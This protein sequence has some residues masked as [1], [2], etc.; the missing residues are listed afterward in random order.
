MTAGVPAPGRGSYDTLI[1]GAGMSGLAAGIRLA[2]FGRRV[3]VLERHTTI[4]GLNSVYRLRGRNF[5]SGLHA[6]TNFACCGDKRGPL[7]K[8]LRQLRLSW[9]DFALAPQRGSSI[10]FPNVR[11]EFNNDLDLL[12]AE[13]A[14]AFPD[15]VDRFEQLLGRLADYEHLGQPEMQVASRAVLGETLSDPLLI[16]MLLCPVLFYGGS[17]PHDMPFGQFSVLFRSIFL[18]GLGRPA[19]GIRPILAALAR[20]YKTRG[21]ELRLRAGVRQIVTDGRRA[22]GVVLD[23]GTELAAENVLSSIGH[24]ETMRLCGDPCEELPPAGRI[25]FVE[26]IAVLDRPASELDLDRAVVFYNDAPRFDFDRPEELTDRR[27]GVVCVPDAYEGAVPPFPAVRLTAL[28]NYDR[29]AALDPAAYRQAKI[30][31]YDAMT[32]SALRFVPDFRPATVDVDT[33]TPTTIERFTGHEQGAVYGGPEKRYDGTTR[34]E[35]LFL[36]GTDQGLVGIIGAILSG[37]TMANA[38]LLR[39]G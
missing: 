36:C 10:V 25:S 22:V 21:G 2:H 15:Q 11:L 38:H 32:A 24:R 30:E 16:E 26:S 18:E 33:F 8:L 1:L 12:R 13:I 5:D 29:W 20:G 7:A 27:S 3:C 19:A 35:N 4:G 28:A 17:R 39:N 9:D 31:Q 37:I 34:L 23:D 6:V 14:R